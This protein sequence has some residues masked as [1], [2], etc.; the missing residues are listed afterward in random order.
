MM[1]KAVSEAAVDK[2]LSKWQNIELDEGE[3]II[4]YTN[5]ILEI[6]CEFDDAG[7][8]IS[9]RDQKRALLKG[10]PSEMM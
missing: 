4:E 8:T 6:V 7:H 10:L 1:L 5:C 9:E 2:K 3:M